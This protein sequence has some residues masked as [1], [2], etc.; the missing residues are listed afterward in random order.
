MD[1]RSQRARGLG[2][3]AG[4]VS[5]GSESHPWEESAEPEAGGTRLL[6]VFTKIVPWADRLSEESSQNDAIIAGSRQINVI[7]SILK[8][9]INPQGIWKPDK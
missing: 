5:P 2:Q 6:Y 1:I 4:Q 9:N 8:E 7:T 3:K